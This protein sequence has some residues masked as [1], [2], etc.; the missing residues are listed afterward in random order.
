MVFC[1]EVAAV[2]RVVRHVGVRGRWYC[3]G[4]LGCVG[5]AALGCMTRIFDVARGSKSGGF[6]FSCDK[7]ILYHISTN[8]TLT[9][10]ASSY[11]HGCDRSLSPV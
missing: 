6:I 8:C 5:S 9:C 4:T 1:G 7:V 2:G 10:A 3:G 11:H